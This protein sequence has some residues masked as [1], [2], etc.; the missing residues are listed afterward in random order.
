MSDQLSKLLTRSQIIIATMMKAELYSTGSDLPALKEEI[1]TGR[2]PRPL[3]VAAADA[4]LVTRQPI[5]VRPV[6][7]GRRR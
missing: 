1:T 7:D 3:L 2:L 5:W 6:D 4:I